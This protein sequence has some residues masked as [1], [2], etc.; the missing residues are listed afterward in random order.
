[1]KCLINRDVLWQSILL[2]VIKLNSFKQSV[3]LA[4][5]L[6]FLQILLSMSATAIVSSI[7][8]CTWR[9][10]KDRPSKSA[11]SYY[12]VN[13]WYDKIFEPRNP[14]GLFWIVDKN[15][16][17]TNLELCANCWRVLGHALAP[18][19]APE[20]VVKRSHCHVPF[21]FKALTDLLQRLTEKKRFSVG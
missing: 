17:C 10:D 18:L 14:E 15:I 16:N 21:S 3:L 13:F 4:V 12:W 5:L 19:L 9:Q 2:F 20:Q 7:R 11:C 1:M 6:A 8:L